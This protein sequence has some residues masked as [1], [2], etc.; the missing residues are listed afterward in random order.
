MK[1]LTAI[2]PL[3]IEERNSD[4]QIYSCFHKEAYGHR[5]RW[6]YHSISDEQ[7]VDDFKTFSEVCD[8]NAKHQAIADARAFAKF[9]KL[10]SDT[11]EMGAGDR[12]TAI[13]WIWDGS[14]EMYDIGY[15]LWSMGISTYDAKGKAIENEIL[16]VC[17]E[18]NQY[19]HQYEQQLMAEAE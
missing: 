8:E 7:L 14:G 1:N 4:L 3:S 6:N 19:T 10:V 5:P 16:A 2:F 11:I 9:E 15:F 18:R 17:A 13:T 12:K